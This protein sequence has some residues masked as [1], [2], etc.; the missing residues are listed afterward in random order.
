MK[1]WRWTAAAVC[2]AAFAGAPVLAQEFRGSILGRVTDPSGAVVPGAAIT[3]TNEETNVSVEV[4]TN[5]EGNYNVPYLLPGRY[6]VSVASPGFR[7]AEQR[8]VIVQ[9]N[10]RIELNLTLEVGATAESV[11]IKAESPMLQTASVDLGQVADRTILEPLLLTSTVLNLANMA[12]GVV[13]SSSLSFGG[14]MG[15]AQN[16]IAVNGGNGTQAGNDVTIDGSPALAPRQSGLAVG[17]PMSDAV[18]EFKIVTTMFDASLGR[19]NGGAISITTKSGTNEFRGSAF[20]YTQNEALNANSWTNKRVGIPRP[21]VDMYAAGVTFGGPVLLPKYNGRNRTFFF[22]AY[23][24][25]RNDN[26]AAGLAFVPT[27]AMRQGD[28]SGVLA[29]TGAPLAIYDPLSTVVNAAGSFV[30]RTVFPN[31]IIPSAR[32][33]PVGLAVIDKLPSPNLSDVKPQ[34]N[35][36]NWS[37]DM[38]FPQITNNT[39]VRIDQSV[40]ARHR[41]FARIAAPQY[42]Q[43]PSPAY[44]VGAY[45]VPPNGTTNLNTDTRRHRAVTLDDTVLFTPTLVGSF[46]LGYTRIFTYN[47]MEGDKQNPADLKL[48]QA[49]TSQQ[50]APAWPIFEIAVDGAPFIGSRPR[51]SVNDIWSFMNNFTKPVGGHNLRFGLDYR[52]TRWNE[53]NPGTQ[54]NGHFVFNN[55]L[56]RSNP[57]QSST[58]NTSGSAMASLLLGMPATSSNRGIGYT[59]P[60]TLQVH[61]GGFFFQDDWKATRR[62]TLNLGLR[63]EMETPPTERFDRLLYSF[64]PDL[65]VGISVPGVGRL[66]GAVRFVNDGGIGRRQGEFDKNNFGPRFGVAFSPGRNVAIRGGYGI[67]YS[68]AVNNI[69]TP[70]TDGA[71]GAL[72]QYVGSTGGDTMPIPGVNI[73]NP[74]PNG[75]VRPTGK[76]LGVATDLGSAVTYVYPRRVLPYVQ[77]WQFSVQKQFSGQILGEVAYVGTHS[78]KLFEDL[79]LN[80]LPDNLLSN[81]TNV[82]NP[83]LGLLPPAS[84]LGQG[85]TVRATQLARRFP[86]FTNVN[87]QRDNTGRLLYH[88]LQTRAQKRFSRG[89]QLVANYT[90]SKS[91]QYFQYSSVNVRKWRTVSPLDY[92]HIFNL[93]LTYQ[94]PVGRGQALGKNWG[95]ALDAAAGGWTLAF[96]AHYKSGDPLTATDTNGTPIPT[97]NPVTPGSVRDR[98]GDRL[99]PVTRLPLNPYFRSD[100][101]IRIPNFGVSP[102]PPRWSWFRGPS[103]FTQTATMSKTIRVSERFKVD[104]R[105]QAQSPFNR[106]VFNNPATNLASP[107]TFGVITAS[108]S[109]GTRTIT[110]GAK[111]RF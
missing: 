68:S 48:P 21:E 29:Q 54:A 18:Q 65:D 13:A 59:S 14:T 110:F 69:G 56:T 91:M 51:L 36:P 70:S 60:L 52:V 61:Y 63:Y 88:S 77:Q 16:N 15:N 87:E 78:V 20:Y 2:L 74:F 6:R 55:T 67:F 72:T 25:N 106:V 105:M 4:R 57:T 32:L 99:D 109:A 49:I 76:S 108:R 50:I 100:V 1:N 94:L 85:S 37:A 42:Q 34:I 98:L 23:E 24:R 39:S 7:T 66:K 111:L 97:A 44:F 26:H 101:W 31:A 40:G 95:R 62:L 107:A 86:H 38:L 73:S 12:P 71:F 80:E 90:H 75:Y 102:E 103:Q 9:I 92:P 10:D 28:F 83:F 64:D 8:G 11:V 82:P 58:G 89:L 53:N 30:S 81:T 35:R 96:F 41:I 27:S 43:A 47:L 104:L 5:Q 33:N 84:S 19:S 79:N 45:S 22:F 93:F 46:R 3:V 17:V